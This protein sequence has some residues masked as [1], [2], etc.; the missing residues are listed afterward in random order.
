MKEQTN[1]LSREAQRLKIVALDQKC[2][3][4]FLMRKYFTKK[5]EQLTHRTTLVERL[6]RTNSTENFGSEIEH[7]KQSLAL[8][9]LYINV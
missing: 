2:S 6:L 4:C 5:H 9:G 7:V 8:A 3:E 1:Q